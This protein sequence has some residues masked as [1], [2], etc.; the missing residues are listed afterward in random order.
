MSVPL[1]VELQPHRWTAIPGTGV[2]VRWD[3]ELTVTVERRGS[4]WDFTAL[5]RHGP[6]FAWVRLAGRP[7]LGMWP[8][9]PLAARRAAR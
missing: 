3:G 2:A 6:V 5:A 1:M 8:I 9:V 4:F 7:E